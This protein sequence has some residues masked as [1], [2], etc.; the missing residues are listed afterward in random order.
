[1]DEII[2]GT[3]SLQFVIQTIL[4]AIVMAIFVMA[5]VSFILAIWDFIRSEGE[6]EAKKK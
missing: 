6:E 4:A 1:M 3:T 2:I 5:I